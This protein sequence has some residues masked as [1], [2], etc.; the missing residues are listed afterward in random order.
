[1]DALLTLTPDQFS[2]LSHSLCSDYRLQQRRSFS[3]LLSPARFRHTIHF[4]NSISMDDKTM[5]IARYLL[6]TL[7]RLT[8]VWDTSIAGRAGQ[9]RLRDFDVV[10]LIMLLCEVSQHDSESL[11]T[12]ESTQWI[13]VLKQYT[14]NNNMFRL[15]AAIGASTV[16]IISSY[17][18]IATRC[19]TFLAATGCAA[20][21]NCMEKEVGTAVEAVVS[22]P[23]VEVGHGMSVDCV[24]CKEE[25]N[26]GRDV[27]QLP[28][29]HIFHWVCILP[30][31]RRRNTCPCCRFQLPTDDVIGEI[32]RLLAIL[33]KEAGRIL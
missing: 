25:M 30:W 20:D 12:S 9:M 14:L 10:L 32:E 19:W 18:D 3:L 13:D 23:S 26:Q 21:G 27:C 24:I 8:T 15:S 5:L 22:L 7:K 33:V 1:M 28:C 31:L 29:Q 6:S 16:T 11:E 4:L 2:H 17:I